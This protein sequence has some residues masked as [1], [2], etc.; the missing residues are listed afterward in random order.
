MEIHASV[1]T[2]G[3]HPIICN[4]KGSRGENTLL[5]GA[6]IIGETECLSVRTLESPTTM[7]SIITLGSGCVFAGNDAG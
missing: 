7:R 3:H 4:L 6:E 5:M 2:I 1:L